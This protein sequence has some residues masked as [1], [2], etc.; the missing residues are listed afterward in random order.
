MWNLKN[1]I[2][3]E[4]RN[5]LMDTENRLMVDRGGGD[6]ELGE[7]GEGIKKYKSV[8]TEQSQRWKR[9]HRECSQ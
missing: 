3:N 7:K 1:K 2:S 9:Q 6:G 5:R 4:N 8:V